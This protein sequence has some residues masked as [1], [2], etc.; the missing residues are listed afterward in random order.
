VVPLDQLGER[1]T[2]A[3]LGTL[4]QLRRPQSAWLREGVHDK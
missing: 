1:F 2:I 4:Q 3:R